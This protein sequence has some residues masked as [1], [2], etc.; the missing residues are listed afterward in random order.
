MSDPKYGIVNTNVN[1]YTKLTNDITLHIIIKNQFNELLPC[2]FFFH[3]CSPIHV[4]IYI[5]FNFWKRYI[6]LS[7]CLLI[8]TKYRIG[9]QHRI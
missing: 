7:K 1:I 6:F 5:L 3:A 9:L 2:V 4:Y 8:V